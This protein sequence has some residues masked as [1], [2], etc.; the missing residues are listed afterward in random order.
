MR[1]LR[2]LDEDL[3]LLGEAAYTVRR[4]AESVA[5]LS[6][7]P[8]TVRRSGLAWRA[9]LDLGPCVVSLPVVAVAEDCGF[10]LD[11]PRLAE[12]GRVYVDR[13]DVEFE[14]CE[15]PCVRLVSGTYDESK[16]LEALRTAAEE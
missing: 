2:L 1:T 10:L 15:R 8:L 12:G 5:E 6:V 14:P 3:R 11:E 7:K 4:V 16:V 13:L 9:V